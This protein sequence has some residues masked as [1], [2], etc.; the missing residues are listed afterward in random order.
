MALV[1]VFVAVLL[2]LNRGRR[3]ETVRLSEMFP[4]GV[5]ISTSVN[6]DRRDAIETVGS[7][8]RRVKLPVEMRVVLTPHSI[9]FWRRDLNKPVIDI[10][11]SRIKYEV[12][13]YFTIAGGFR[14]LKARVP[15]DGH[16]VEIPFFPLN[17]RKIWPT[18][19]PREDLERIA[20]HLNRIG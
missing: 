20:D 3:S 2:V 7:F 16:D 17:T 9:Q 12:G 8:M 11:G 13:E 1:A 6:N 19:L 14:C 15:Y 18:A 5:V 4:H 10:T